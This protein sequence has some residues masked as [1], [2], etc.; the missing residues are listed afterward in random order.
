MSR[1]A[2]VRAQS[3]T[4]RHARDQQ[5]VTNRDCARVQKCQQPCHLFVH[6]FMYF[7]FYFILFYFIFLFF[8]T[9]DAVLQLHTNV[10]T[11]FTALLL[12]C[13][14]FCSLLDGVC[15]SGNTRITYLLTYSEQNGVFQ[16]CGFS[17][18]VIE[19]P[20]FCDLLHTSGTVEAR[21]FK[22]GRQI[23]H[24]D[25]NEKNAKLGQHGREQGQVTY[26]FLN[27]GTPQRR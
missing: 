2:S 11:C 3:V 19:N 25:T 10:F 12:C 5:N 15:L 26:F 22:F 17:R 13:V 18:T 20:K 6:F 7:L 9:C 27:F 8:F 16:A 23:G 1:S 24:W 4:L 21:N 14:S